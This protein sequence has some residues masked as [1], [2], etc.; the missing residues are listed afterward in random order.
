[1]QKL[2]TNF[3]DGQPFL[4]E[5]MNKTNAAV[6]K[7]MDESANAVSLTYQQLVAL[8]TAEALIAGQSYRITDYETVVS[9]E[10]QDVRSAGHPFDLLVVAIDAKTLSEKAKA[11]LHDAD[12]YFADAKL[13]AWEVWY[14]IDNDTK[15]FAW[16]DEANGKGVIYRL[17]DEYNNDCPYD[18]KNIQFKRWAITNIESSSLTQDA[19]SSLRDALVYDNNGGKCFATKDVYGEWV[20]A[21]S[22]GTEY[23]VDENTFDFYYTFQGMSTDDGET[24]SE[25]YDMS[26]HPLKLSD[27]C[28]DFLVDEG[29]GAN[30]VDE[31]HD[32]VLKPAFYEYFSDDEYAKGRQ[33]LNNVVFL[34]GLSYCYFNEDDDYWDYNTS[35]CFGNVF[36]VEC[37]NSTFG[38]GCYN[39]TFGNRSGT[40]VAA[41]HSGTVAP[42]THSGTTALAIRSGTV[43]TT[44]RSGTISAIT[45]SGTTATAIRSGTVVAAIHSG[46][47]AIVTHSG[48]IVTIT[49]S[50]T[51][52][53]ITHSGTTATGTPQA[54]ISRTTR[55]GT[56]AT[57]IR[58]GTVSSTTHSGTVVAAIH[59][60]TTATAI[61]SGTM[62]KQSLCLTGFSMCRLQAVRAVRPMCR[63]PKFST[64]RRVQTATISC[65]SALL[66]IKNTPK[67]RPSIRAATW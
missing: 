32:N 55:S 30:L 45:R 57:A 63:T 58:S 35:S 49:R 51:V 50:G 53:P 12:E 5:H 18:F 54:I 42:I 64:V 11:M 59:S 37:K 25:K 6:N 62:C 27:E 22:N 3:V 48:T 33:V 15:R 23:V 19:L 40:I 41:I 60:G 13:E 17:I 26:A 14:C 47:I 44:I 66:R 43:V 10:L 8:K 21:D 29:S 28:I 52:A 1:M 4:A 9:G 34:N 24:V 7:L 56:T 20:P 31:C 16:A 39:N 67:L 46:T 36:G 61:R 38:N 2:K 65:K